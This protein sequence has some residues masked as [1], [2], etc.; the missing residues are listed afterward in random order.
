VENEIKVSQKAYMSPIRT[1]I[2]NPHL[3]GRVV[4]KAQDL[5]VAGDSIGVI[6][7][8]AYAHPTIR[9]TLKTVGQHATGLV[10]AKYIVLKV[11]SP[12]RRID[13]LHS[14]PE[15]IDAD[16]DDPKSRKTGVFV[17]SA[18]KLLGEG[19]LF[20]MNERHR[21]GFGEIRAGRKACAAAE[22][23]C[24]EQGCANTDRARARETS[25]ANR[26]SFY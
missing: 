20:R 9:C 13:H 25:A 2:E 1:R 11:E 19:G 17:Q 12:L 26:R 18:R 14:E 7:E 8:H 5:L 10:A 15:T 4:Q 6:D 21:C 3:D 22:H 24:G 16:I 23:G